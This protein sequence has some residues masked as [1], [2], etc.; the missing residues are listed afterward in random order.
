MN[1]DDETIRRHCRERWYVS[2]TLPHNELKA[3]QHL[4]AQGFRAFLPMQDRTIRHARR[5]STVSRPV[6]PRYLFVNFDPTVTQ[7]RSINGTIGI[8]RLLMC[9]EQPEPVKAGVV[10]TLIASVDGDD[11]LQ[12]HNVLKQGDRVRLLDGPFADQLGI[13]ESLGPNERVHVLLTFLGGPVSV[14]LDRASLALAS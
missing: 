2:R 14:Q 11:R 3:K 8:D 9:G 1:A 13:L 5:I 7:W 6:F 12:F 10:E 4:I